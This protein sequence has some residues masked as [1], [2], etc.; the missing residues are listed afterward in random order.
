MPAGIF[1]IW[2]ALHLFYG[3]TEI[4]SHKV[5]LPR[6]LA[7]LFILLISVLCMGQPFGWE[8]GLFYWLFALMALGVAFVQLRVFQPSLVMLNTAASLVIL[9]LAGINVS[10]WPI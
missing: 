1:L 10:G 4:H 5:A 7:G 2:P 6:R 8:Q 9:V 3:V